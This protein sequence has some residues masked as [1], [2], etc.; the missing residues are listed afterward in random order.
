MTVS[1]ATS[2]AASTTSTATTTSAATLSKD[3]NTFLRLLSTQLQNQDPLDPMDTN[4]F[5]Q[6]LVMYSQVEQQIGTNTR[7]DSLVSSQA[8]TQKN[9]LTST[10]VGYIGKDITYSGTKT[11]FDGTNPVKFSY[12]FETVPTKSGIK[13]LDSSGQVIRTIEG[14]KTVGD[15]AVT[16][17]GTNDYGEKVPTGTYTIQA[18]LFDENSK[19]ID[20][21]T[22]M[23]AT[24]EGIETDTDGTIWLSLNGGRQT[25]LDKVLT[26]RASGTTLANTNTSSN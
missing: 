8:A 14:S 10:S 3:F 20:V 18:N 12:A 24:V 23:Q 1:S 22:K 9:L 19:S 21:T 4:Q 6:Q 2:T 13:I 17:D 5:T 7:L 11:Y 16:W 15:N 25:S 26:V